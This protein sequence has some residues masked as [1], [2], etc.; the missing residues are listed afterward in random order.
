MKTPARA[1]N[2]ARLY[3]VQALYQKKIADN[4]FSELKIQYYADNADSHYTDWDLF[5]RLIDAVKTNQD[6]ID[7]YIKENSS[8]GVESINYVDYVVLQVAIAELIECLENPY[9]VILK[10]YVEI[11]YSMGTEEGYKFIN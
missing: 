3:A 7:K 5:Y 1:R 6:T 2:N 9:Q 11:C 4:T 8:N 10:D